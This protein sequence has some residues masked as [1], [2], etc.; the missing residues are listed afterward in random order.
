MLSENYIIL[1]EDTQ[2]KNFQKES[3]EYMSYKK[4]AKMNLSNEIY[5]VYDESINSKY[6]VKVNNKTLDRIKNS[7]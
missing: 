7:F 2:Y 6:N 1:T 3:E 5:K 4:I